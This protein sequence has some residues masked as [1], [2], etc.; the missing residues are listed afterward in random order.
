M[1]PNSNRSFSD[2]VVSHVESWQPSL[3]RNSSCFHLIGC[4]KQASI[5]LDGSNYL[6]GVNIMP[7]LTVGSS[8]HVMRSGPSCCCA[9]WQ[10]SEVIRHTMKR[11][12]VIWKLS[13]FFWFVPIK[14]NWCPPREVLICSFG[15][16]GSWLDARSLGSLLQGGSLVSDRLLWLD[17]CCNA[18]Y[19]SA[20]CWIKSSPTQTQI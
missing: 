13:V 16:R 2:C 5:L 12:I 20:N 17:G 14:Q 6:S 4:L 7:W 1:W 8:C 15:Q 19:L 9:I 11:N 18:G 10:R 3:Q